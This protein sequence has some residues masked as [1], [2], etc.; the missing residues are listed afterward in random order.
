MIAVQF[1]GDRLG[2]RLPSCNTQDPADLEAWYGGFGFADH[3]RKVVLANCRE[4]ERAR[5]ATKDWK[6][7]EARLDDLARTSDAYIDFLITHLRGSRTPRRKRDCIEGRRMM[8]KEVE[9][10]VLGRTGR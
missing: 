4:I 9:N 8:A 5:A 7:S 2:E 6:L 1:E 3:W 10:A